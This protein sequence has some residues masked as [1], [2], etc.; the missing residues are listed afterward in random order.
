M[1]TLTTSGIVV[2]FLARQSQGVLLDRVPPFKP[3]ANAFFFLS[4]CVSRSRQ[5]RAES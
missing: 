5:G 2:F 3:S 4:C 1:F